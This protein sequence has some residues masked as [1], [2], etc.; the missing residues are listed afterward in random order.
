MLT[1]CVHVPPP[2]LRIVVVLSSRVFGNVQHA[3][4]VLEVG[5]GSSSYLAAG[6]SASEDCQVVWRS[7]LF[8][9]FCTIGRRKVLLRRKSWS[10]SLRLW[11]LAHQCDGRM[12]LPGEVQSLLIGCQAAWRLILKC[13]NMMCFCQAVWWVGLVLLT[14]C[15]DASLLRREIV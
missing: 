2:H 3:G 9:R 4:S 10:P 5:V 15:V 11:D 6:M 14:N 8:I 12:G 1:V 7:T 13:W